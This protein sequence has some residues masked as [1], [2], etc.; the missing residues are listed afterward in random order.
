MYSGHKFS[1]EIEALG[2]RI[3]GQDGHLDQER[4]PCRMNNDTTAGV[5]KAE[6]KVT[7][8]PITDWV[9]HVK[10]PKLVFNLHGVDTKGIPEY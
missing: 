3:K 10:T 9:L 8:F 5:S 7:E 4:P 2:N 1:V 6:D